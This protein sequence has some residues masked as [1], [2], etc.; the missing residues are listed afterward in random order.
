MS[1]FTGSVHGRENQDIRNT[2]ACIIFEMENFKR[3]GLRRKP[4]DRQEEGTSEW[5]SGE[6]GCV[7][8]TW[9]GDNEILLDSVSLWCLFN[10]AAIYLDFIASNGE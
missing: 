10:D 2:N 3:K 4:R 1:S 6:V 7:R 5:I 9:T 8:V